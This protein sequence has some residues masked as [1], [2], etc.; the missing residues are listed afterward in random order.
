MLQHRARIVLVSILCLC[1]VFVSTLGL[2]VGMGF[3]LGLSHSVLAAR[4]STASK[5]QPSVKSHSLINLGTSRSLAYQTKSDS[6]C[7]APTTAPVDWPEYG[8]DATGA[9]DNTAETILS[10]SSVPAGFCLAW[11]S[12][13]PAGSIP[14][15]YPIVLGGNL[16]VM[17]GFQQ[18][19]AFNSLTGTDAGQSWPALTGNGAVSLAG[20]NGVVYIA[21]QDRRAYAF[22][23]T[24]GV[25]SGEHLYNASFGGSAISLLNGVVYAGFD[26]DTF[27]AINV[28]SGAIVWKVSMGGGIETVPVV[29]N[30]VAYAAAGDN[31]IYAV[32]ISTKQMLWNTIIRGGIFVSAQP[33]VNTPGLIALP[34]NNGA[35]SL[36]YI[37]CGDG[38]VRAYNAVTGALY[39]TQSTPTLSASGGGLAADSS[40]IYVGATDSAGNGCLLALNAATGNEAWCSSTGAQGT[41]T[42]PAVAN[43]VVYVGVPGNSTEEYVLAATDGTALLAQP[44][45]VPTSSNGQIVVNGMLYIIGQNLYAYALA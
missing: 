20:A 18:V 10:P 26:D 13:L 43:G 45:S 2:G 12:N 39:W 11:T 40:H 42:T 3:G 1:I 5:P 17:D 29:L 44:I 15:P 25:E 31:R 16:Y 4:A 8:F 28:T 7:V 19:L 37:L 9:R 41:A 22:N 35:P 36:I 38:K 33:G 21:G 14:T 27:D 30:G 34:A 6:S 32:N 24:S 23:A